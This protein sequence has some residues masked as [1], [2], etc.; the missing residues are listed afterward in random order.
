MLL[1]SFQSTSGTVQNNGC[2]KIGLCAKLPK[3]KLCLLNSFQ[4]CYGETV[5]NFCPY[6]AVQKEKKKK[7]KKN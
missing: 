1:S 7:K 6:V 2:Y 3:T 4:P 5:W